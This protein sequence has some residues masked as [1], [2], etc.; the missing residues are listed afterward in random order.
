MGSA[1]RA[2][3]RWTRRAMAEEVALL[4]PEG[5]WEANAAISRQPLAALREHFLIAGHELRCGKYGARVRRYRVDAGKVASRDAGALRALS[6]AT[7]P[8][9][10]RRG[11]P[12]PAT[13][14]YEVWEGSRR[15]GGY[16]RRTERCLVDAVWA[17]LPDGGRKRLS[18][19]HVLGVDRR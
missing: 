8:A 13:V 4:D 14:T 12:T 16:V 17:Y 1:E 5:W 2:W 18:G 6:E 3:S 9:P 15:R 10:S 11:A 19:T 7:F